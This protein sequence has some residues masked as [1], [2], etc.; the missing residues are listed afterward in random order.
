[1]TD[2]DPPIY[3]ISQY[4]KQVNRGI[5][6]Y[7]FEQNGS[8]NQQQFLDAVLERAEQIDPEGAYRF[9]EDL[10]GNRILLSGGSPRATIEFL[11]VRAEN[12]CIVLVT[13][14]IGFGFKRLEELIDSVDPEHREDP[15]G[16]EL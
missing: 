5:H 15:K 3:K 12:K 9:G 2:Q 8:F 11:P 1:M 7:I 16:K 14:E 10:N 4:G 6:Q 13:N